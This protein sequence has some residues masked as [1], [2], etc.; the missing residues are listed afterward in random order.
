LAPLL[1]PSL[2]PLFVNAVNFLIDVEEN[3]AEA[4]V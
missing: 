2:R 4:G 1:L 3:S